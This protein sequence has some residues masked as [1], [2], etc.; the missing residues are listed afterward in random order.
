MA[1]SVVVPLGITLIVVDDGKIG[2]TYEEAIGAFSAVVLLAGYA[3]VV[4]RLVEALFR[5][6]GF[7][8]R[9]SNSSLWA[10]RILGAPSRNAWQVLARAFVSSTSIHQH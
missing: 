8:A 10:A 7:L 5:R 1:I 6:F 4:G 3:V 2:W 9:S